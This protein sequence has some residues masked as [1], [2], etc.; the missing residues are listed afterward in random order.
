MHILLATMHTHANTSKE[1]ATT[2]VQGIIILLVSACNPYCV[3]TYN[4][5]NRLFQH[6]I[7]YNV[8]FTFDFNFGVVMFFKLTMI[9]EHT[10]ER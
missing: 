10:E 4:Q 8:L 1:N 5:L 2:M 7:I 6:F 3:H 9:D